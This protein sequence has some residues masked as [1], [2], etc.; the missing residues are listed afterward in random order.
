MILFHGGV[1]TSA[2]RFVSLILLLGAMPMGVWGQ[3]TV[4]S[5]AISSSLHYRESGVPD[6]VG[7]SNSAVVT[8]RA[9][10]GKDNNSTVEL[11]TGKLDSNTTPP[12]SFA[13]V[14]FEPFTPSGVPLLRK[15]FSHLATPAGYYSFTWPSLYRGEQI[16]VRSYV[17]GFPEDDP[18][19]AYTTVK[20]RPDLAMQNLTFPETAIVQQ[21]VNIRANIAE[22]NGDSG[23][24][25]ACTLDVDGNTVDQVN[26]VYVAAGGGV[27]CEFSYTFSGAGTH[28]IQVTAA[29][30]VPGDWDL[31]NNTASGT[32]TI[33]TNNAEH[34]TGIFLD[35]NVNSPSQQTHSYQVTYQGATVFSYSNTSGSSIHLQGASTLIQD[36]GCMGSTTAAAWQLPVDI[37]Y[38]ESMDGTQLISFTDKGLNAIGTSLAVVP[39]PVCNSTAASVV[40]QYGSNF[41]TDHF[42][43]IGY[44]QYRDSAGNPLYSLQFVGVQR[45]AGD[46]TYFSHGYQCSWWNNCSNPADFYAWNT[47]TQ[48]Q[49]GTLLPL[50]STWGS[51]IASQDASGNTLAAQ[52]SAP[53]NGTLQSNVVPTSC[54]DIGPDA[55]GYTYHYCSAANYQTTVAMGITA[56]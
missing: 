40:A 17:T 52:V 49:W 44:V 12:G 29:N 37:S 7:E 30:P 11:T 1:H 24:T 46:V 39:F 50:G 2:K 51:S 32:I 21:V 28:A 14:R 15:Y 18:V 20:L 25:T 22:L 41:V 47:S 42:D 54:A 10:L 13:S 5:Y 38:T 35:S 4:P 43:Y 19:T 36:Y 23:A 8:A 34:A 55:N 48:T 31:S 45:E 26:G 16:Q 53:L 3:S 27:T 9:L 33:S 6:G 56:Y